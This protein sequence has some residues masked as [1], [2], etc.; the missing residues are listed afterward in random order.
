MEPGAEFEHNVS[1][2]VCLKGEFVTKLGENEANLMLVADRRHVFPL[3]TLRRYFRACKFIPSGH[4]LVQFPAKSDWLALRC[5]RALTLERLVIG[6]P[7]ISVSLSSSAFRF[8]LILNS[9]QW[10]ISLHGVNY[11]GYS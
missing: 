6:S 5:A 2:R 4:V 1:R 11:C 3:T 8:H 7:V 10:A 9:N